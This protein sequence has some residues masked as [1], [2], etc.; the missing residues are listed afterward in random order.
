MFKK[1]MAV[2]VFLAMV[3]NYTLFS[4]AIAIDTAISNIA[5]DI[6]E[7]VPKGS[8][9][10]VLNIS[11]DSTD[12]SDYIINEL[13]TNLINARLFQIV[14]RSTVE[15]EAAKRE[16][17]FQMSGFVSD[18]SQK[19]LGKFLGAD[20]IITGTIAR[21]SADSYRL[22]LNSIHLESFTYQ[23]ASRITIKD[24]SQMKAII[25]G[26]SVFYED[27]T[28]GERLGMGG[29]NMV[30]G[31]G[32]ILNGHRLGWITTLVEGTGVIILVT[33]LLMNPTFAGM[34]T[35][36]RWEEFNDYKVAVNTRNTMITTGCVLIGAGVL[37]G[38]VI[39]FFH[40]KPNNTNVAQNDFPFKLELASSNNQDINGLRVLYK[41]KF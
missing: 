38:F 14:P 11:S 5:K 8:K 2:F 6:S 31:L 3:T 9:I 19:R 12:L 17:D 41:M 21:A 37:Y 18:E 30:F 4:Q 13:I 10:A 27:Y 33:G 36:D 23:S 24:D 28:V 16:F 22:V 40:H 26:S 15:M 20:T 39:P 7:S 32:S 35:D 29:L 1:K 25:A 34:A